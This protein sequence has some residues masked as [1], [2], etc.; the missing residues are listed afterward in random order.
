MDIKDNEFIS[1]SELREWLGISRSKSYEMLRPGP[2]SLPAYRI[3]RSVRVRRQ[4]VEEWLNNNTY[5]PDNK[6]DQE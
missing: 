2:R 4:D 1:I 6:G 3:G 5:H